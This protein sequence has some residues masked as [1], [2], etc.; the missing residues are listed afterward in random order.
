MTYHKIIKAALV[1]EETNNILILIIF[2][3]CEAKAI[4]A[5]FRFVEIVY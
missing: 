5:I 4:D 2:E 1:Y 3:V